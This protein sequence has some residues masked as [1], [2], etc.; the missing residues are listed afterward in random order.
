M[1][2]RPAHFA[3]SWYPANTDECKKTIEALYNP[4]VSTSL[5]NAPTGGIVPH[6]GWY[7]SGNLACRV[8]QQLAVTDAPDL[9]VIFGGHLS[10]H[11]PGRIMTHGAWETPLGLLPVAEDFTAAVKGQ[12]DLIIDKPTTAPPD[13]TIELQLP[14]IRYFWGAIPIVPIRLPPTTLAIEVGKAVATIAR[15]RNTTIQVIGS[16]DLTHYG[17]NYG[18]TPQG[19]GPHAVEWVRQHNDHGMI[20]AVLAMNPQAVLAEASANQNS[21][22]AGA[23]AGAIA[24][25]RELGATIA[26]AMDYTTSYDKQPGDSFVG[27]L[28]ALFQ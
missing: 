24:A 22:C 14:F 28:A 12:F 9:I 7:F 11:D 13:N 21:C 1:Q 17:P 6:A 15:E 16:T 5:K 19:T 3:G 25:G 27:Y 23:V 4:S 10:S 26:E 2:I 18:F 8:F 20:E